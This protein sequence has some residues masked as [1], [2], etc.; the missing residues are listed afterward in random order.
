MQGH[1][2]TPDAETEPTLDALAGDVVGLLEHLD[3]PRVDVLGYSLGGL[4]ALQLATR[5]AERL[6]RL[7]VVSAHTRIGGFHP[8]VHDPERE[9]AAPRGLTP[10]TMAGLRD[11]YA[12]V[13][14]AGA[15]PDTALARYAPLLSAGEH[16]SDDTLARITA[17]TLVM[18]GDHDVISVE[19]AEHVHSTIPGAQ[20]AVVPGA[21]HELLYDALEVV[22]PVLRRFLARRP[23]GRVPYPALG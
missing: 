10:A 4:I 15:S 12:R 23:A 7:V 17:Q 9:A 3:V 13:A 1:G 19:H 20:L 11:E 16:W 5:H 14:P 21:T 2:R 6:D 18:V 8:E 22:A